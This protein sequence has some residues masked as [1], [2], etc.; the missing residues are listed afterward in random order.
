VSSL[1][2]L[3]SV[4]LDAERQNLSDT[5]A[6]LQFS[7]QSLSSQLTASSEE[8]EKLEQLLLAERERAEDFENTLSRLKSENH[9]CSPSS[10]LPPHVR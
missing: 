7:N 9:R 6:H 3:S 2:L 1:C 10:L 5:I 4:R 8:R